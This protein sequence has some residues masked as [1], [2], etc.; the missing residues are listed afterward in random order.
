[1]VIFEF[2]IMARNKRINLK[3]IKEIKI[4][5]I[6]LDFDGV[7]TNNKVYINEDGKES[8]RCDR[9]DG[10][11][12]SILKKIGLKL[13]IISTEKNNVV[14][15]RSKKLGIKCYYNQQNKF[16]KI[17]ELEKNKVIV[18]NS[19]LYIGNDI[20]DYYSMKLFYNTACPADS[21]PEIKKLSKWKLRSKG[22]EGI[23]HE[24]ATKIL[25]LKL[26]EII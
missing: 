16:K 8:V 23:M 17:K 26:I 25:R 19:C 11:V 7:L 9:S 3:R 2:C 18:L 14:Y 5:T 15:H 20:N 1:M 24:V 12:I 6:L 4:D 22:G 21:H 10:L 13:F